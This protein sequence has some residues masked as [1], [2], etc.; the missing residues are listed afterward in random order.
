MNKSI[1]SIKIPVINTKEQSGSSSGSRVSGSEPDRKDKMGATMVNRHGQA[2][3]M[4][5]IKVD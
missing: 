1:R 3:K 5:N 4:V 2:Q